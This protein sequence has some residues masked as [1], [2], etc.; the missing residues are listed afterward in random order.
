MK[1]EY[2]NTFFHLGFREEFLPNSF[3]IVTACNPMDEKLSEEVNHL[4]NE[5]LKNNLKSRNFLALPVLGKSL[6][7][8]HEE[9]SFCVNCTKE[10]AVSLAESYD[11]RAIFW[12]DEDNLEIID[13]KLAEVEFLGSFKARILNE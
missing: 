4:R 5:R 11:Q 10:E 6:D 7:G 12:I 13:C 9:K 2:A 1:E 3:A 8:L